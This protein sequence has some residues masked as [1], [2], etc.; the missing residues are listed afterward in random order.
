MTV[1]TLSME[2]ELAWGVHDMDEE[3]IS[4]GRRAESEFFDR[5]LARCDEAGV[6]FSFDVVGH[7]FEASCDGT[8]GDHCS[9]DWFDADPGTDAERNPEFYAPDMVRAMTATDVDHEICTHSYSHIDC[10]RF[11]AD[12]V[13]RDLELAQAVH[14]RDLG[15]RTVS[16]VP[17]RH[18]TPPTDA[19]R[20]AGIEIV[21]M[22]RTPPEQSPL[23]TFSDHLFGT[24][25]GMSLEY[26]DGIVFTY[27]SKRAS[28]I[29][30][31]LPKGQEETHPALRYLPLSTSQR[32]R[33]HLGTLRRSVEEAIETGEPLHLWCHLHDMANEEQWV[34]I[35]AFLGWLGEQADAG[36]IELLTMEELNERARDGRLPVRLTGDDAATGSDGTPTRLAERTVDTAGE[37]LR[38][39]ATDGGTD[40]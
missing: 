31:L 17:P 25:D 27:C 8:H 18:H 38:R 40:S 2:V 33:H 35:A 16:F 13:R 29:S 10:S 7:L 24:H 9:P 11:D 20:A 5:L 23:R 21:R 1:V 34:G 39:T 15:E 32:Q 19:L 28:L 26:R 4:P 30:S 12:T 36:R 22:A 37:E 14:E 3:R 6:P